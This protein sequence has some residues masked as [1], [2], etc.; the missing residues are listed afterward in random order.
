MLNTNGSRKN[1]T[2]RSF[3]LRRCP[4]HD[5]NHDFKLLCRR[6]RDGAFATQHDR[7]RILTLVAN[8]LHEG[9]FRHLRA[10]G[11]RSKHIEHLVE[12][13]KTQRISTGTFKNRMTALRWLSEK[14]D[15]QNIVARD[16]AH[17]G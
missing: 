8:Q 10:T 16:N 9:G 6:N 2:S 12:R 1:T 17:Y 14:I 11:V 15:K 7:E 13:W 5:L 3:H 4:M